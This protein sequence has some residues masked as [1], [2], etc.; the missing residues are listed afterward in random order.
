MII[1]FHHHLLLQDGY[2]DKLVAEMDRLGIRYTCLSGLGIGHGRQD[3]TDYQ[4]FSLGSLSPDNNDVFQVMQKYPDRIIGQWVLDLD[5]HT[6][7]M[8]GEAKDR[9]FRGLKITRPRKDYDADCYMPFYEEAERQNMSILFHTGMILTTCFDKE[10]DVSSNRMRPMQLD[11]VAR[12]CPALKMVIAHMG[13]PWF[14]EAATM[15]RYHDNVFVDFTGSA[16]GWRNRLSPADF[17]KLMFWKDAFRKVV[18][19]TDVS[20]SEMEE[21]LQDQRQLF[22]LLNLDDETQELIFHKNAEHLLCL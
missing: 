21:S 14:D 12:R 18:F 20:F 7:E 9:G 22:R 8:I 6:P 4:K 2:E 3:Q 15:V 10:D 16:Y 1:D 17:Q 19:G 11:R 5:R 13:Y